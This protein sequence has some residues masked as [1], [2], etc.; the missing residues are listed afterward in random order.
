MSRKLLEATRSIK[1]D[2]F[3]DLATYTGRI[4]KDSSFLTHLLDGLAKASKG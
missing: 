2:V 4:F 1:P 3:D